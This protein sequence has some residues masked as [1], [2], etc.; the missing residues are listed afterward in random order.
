[1]RDDCR[2][3]RRRSRKH[4]IAP[5]LAHQISVAFVSQEHGYHAKDPNAWS[6]RV[7]SRERRSTATEYSTRLRAHRTTESGIDFTQVQGPRDEVKPLCPA[8]LYCTVTP[9][10]AYKVLVT[11]L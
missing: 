6:E 7:R 4:T 2:P 5:Y 1:V 11:E 9:R 3:C 10:E 8:F